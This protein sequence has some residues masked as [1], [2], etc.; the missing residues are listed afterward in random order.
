MATSQREA[1]YPRTRVICE[2]VTCGRVIYG[3]VIYGRVICAHV[4]YGRVVSF[5]G[6]PVTGLSFMGVSS[7]DFP[8]RP[9]EAGIHQKDFPDLALETDPH[10]EV[11]PV[12]EEGS[13]AS[14]GSMELRETT[15]MDGPRSTTATF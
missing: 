4:I 11:T 1:C 5:M 12:G 6:M 8:Q 13:A 14:G 10:P 15:Q 7:P 3:R 9:F 2:R